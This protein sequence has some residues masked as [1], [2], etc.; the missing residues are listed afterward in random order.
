MGIVPDQDQE[1]G[2]KYINEIKM[3]QMTS[4]E[5]MQPIDEKTGVLGDLEDVL[6]SEQTQDHADQTEEDK[7]DNPDQSASPVQPAVTDLLL[8]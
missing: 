7:E 6:K 1:V 3:F 4:Q 2:A 5:S 8:D